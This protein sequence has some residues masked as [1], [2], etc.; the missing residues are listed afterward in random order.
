ME[1]MHEHSLLCKSCNFPA[2]VDSDC[3]AKRV[4]AVFCG[5]AVLQCLQACLNANGDT[6]EHMPFEDEGACAKVKQCMQ[7]SLTCGELNS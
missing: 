7:E 1:D 6:V 4:Q 2:T 3:I 5:V